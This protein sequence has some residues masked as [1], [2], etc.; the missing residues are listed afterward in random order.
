MKSLLDNYIVLL[1]LWEETEKTTKGSDI[2]AHIIGVASRMT[3]FDLYFGV[4]LGEMILRHSDNL[5]RALQKKDLSVAEGQH[6]ASLV[7]ATLQ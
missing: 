1:E 6:T 4:C 7:K 3:N 5:S 2:T